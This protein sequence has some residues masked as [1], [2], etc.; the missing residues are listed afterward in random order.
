MVNGWVNGT[1]QNN[2]IIL[3]PY[4]DNPEN[5]S[6]SIFLHPKLT[7]TYEADITEPSINITAPAKDAAL[8]GTINIEAGVTDP[9]GIKKVEFYVGG[10]L[11]GTDESSPYT[12]GWDTTTFPNGSYKLW[13]KTY[14]NAGNAGYTNYFRLCDTFDNKTK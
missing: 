14:D 6:D 9:S 12:V 4:I 1:V 7:V 2:G 13:A 3:C 10:A 8:S 11:L 5:Y